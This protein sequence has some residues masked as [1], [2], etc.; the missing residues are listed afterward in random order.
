MKSS[1]TNR[2]IFS[3]H[4]LFKSYFHLSCCCFCKSH[5]QYI[6]GVN[7]R[8]FYKMSDTLNNDSCLAGSRSGKHHHR[9]IHMR[10]GSFLCLIKISHTLNFSIALRIRFKDSSLP[11]SSISSVAPPGVI[12]LPETAVRIGHIT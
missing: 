8:F 6:S 7:S 9:P 11:R 2:N 3:S 10:Y 5:D 1:K 12:C 4:Q